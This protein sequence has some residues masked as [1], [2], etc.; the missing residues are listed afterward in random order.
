[1]STFNLDFKEEDRTR[2]IALLNEN[3]ISFVVGS[4]AAENTMDTTDTSVDFNQKPGQPKQS[5]DDDVD[6]EAD[7]HVNELAKDLKSWLQ[8]NCI[9]Q[10]LFAERYLKRGKGT[11]SDYLS[12]PSIPYT[13]QEMEV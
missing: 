3:S 2:L 9:N 13:K 7:V 8:K 6:D 5:T 1:M 11:M 10:G 4:S 12:K